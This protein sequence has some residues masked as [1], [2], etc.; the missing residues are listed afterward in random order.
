MHHHLVVLHHGLWGTS[1]HMQWMG[2]KLRSKFATDAKGD[3]FR[4]ERDV[5][6]DSD[7]VGLEETEHAQP[8]CPS[9]EILNINLN[10]GVSTYD[11]IDICG[12]RVA[13]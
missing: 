8:L 6:T 5:D 3:I 13:V 1:H 2:E 10:K 11:G 12:G 7:V 4:M 9:I